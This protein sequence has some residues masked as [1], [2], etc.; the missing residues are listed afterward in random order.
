MTIFE[1]TEDNMKD[2]PKLQTYNDESL[3][4]AIVIVPTDEIHD[5]GYRCMTYVFC[6]KDK[7]VGIINCGSDVLH[8]DWGSYIDPLE[9]EK[10][11]RGWS[12]DC[13]PNGFLRIF[14][15]SGIKNMGGC[16]SYCVYKVKQ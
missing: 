4:D 9:Q 13:T 2:L 7:A 11:S 10:T 14:N 16:S 8:L 6:K 1:I 12:I 3:Y 15:H 5:S